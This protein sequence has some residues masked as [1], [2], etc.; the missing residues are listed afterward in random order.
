MALALG[1]SFLLDFWVFGAS[2]GPGVEELG[3]KD[4]FVTGSKSVRNPLLQACSMEKV[5]RP[6]MSLF[7]FSGLVMSIEKAA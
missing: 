2:F 3:L 5:S 7:T 1:K 6:L 4:T